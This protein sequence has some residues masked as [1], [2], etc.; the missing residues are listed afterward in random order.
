MVFLMGL[1]AASR[2]AD[3]LLRNGSFAE[4]L[5][6]WRTGGAPSGEVQVVSLNDGP[7]P[8]AVRVDA[9]RI[10]WGERSVASK[11]FP[12]Q[13]SK[14]YEVRG[15]VKRLAGYG[16]RL[17]VAVVWN[18]AAGDMIGVDNVWHDVLLGTD[19]ARHGR[20]VISPANAVTAQIKAGIEMG[21]GE[22]NAALITGLEF[23][24]APPVGPDAAIHLFAGK[25]VP[26]QPTDLMLHA[27][28]NGEGSRLLG[29]EA[30]RLD[31][32]KVRG[33]ELR[34][35]SKTATEL[36]LQWKAA[37]D[38]QWKAVPVQPLPAGEW[39]DVRFSAAGH[40]SWTGQIYQFRLVFKESPEQVVL[41]WIRTF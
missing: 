4:G 24:P 17:S 41:D 32:E 13:P 14:A 28:L 7:V 36:A 3:N 21:T 1:C 19:W 38:A 18:N 40:P 39:T 33:M 9:R 10:S 2:G 26:E 37:P 22:R 11:P 16:Y 15:L 31:A 35:K 30:I 34:L 25:T 12:I 23:V 5:D 6:G 20:R 29:P 27:F 8:H